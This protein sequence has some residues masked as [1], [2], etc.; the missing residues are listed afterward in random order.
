MSIGSSGRFFDRLGHPVGPAVHVGPQDARRVGEVFAH[1]IHVLDQVVHVLR[2]AH[3]GPRWSDSGRHYPA[4]LV[5]HTT[6][7]A[8]PEAAHPSVATTTASV[9][10]AIVQT[11]RGGPSRNALRPRLRP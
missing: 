3:G 6:Q 10:I 7:P 9:A 4:A 11:V 5:L 8:S 1:H 2:F